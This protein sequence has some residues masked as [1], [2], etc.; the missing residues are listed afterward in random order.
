MKIAKKIFK[1]GGITLLLL[2]IAMIAIPF[3]FKDT[4]KEKV[5]EMAN[6]NL[7]A[8]IALQDVDIS[9]FKNF[10]KAQVTLNDFVLVNKEPFVGDTLFA[11]KHID[12]TLSIKDLLAGNYNLLG[13]NVKDASVYIHLNKEGVGNFD[14]AIPSDKP[15]EES[16][17]IKLDIQQYN[18]ENLK[19]T[20]KMDD[21]NLFMEVADI[22]HSGKGNF[23]EE[24][25]DLDTQ[26]KANVTFAM[27]K[28]TFMKQ[29]PITLQAILGIDLK[30]QKYTFKQNKAT[31]NRLDLV[32]DGFIQLLEEGQRY[33]LTFSTPTN[34]FQNFL[35]LI[36]E[37]YSKSIENVKTTGNL[38][39]KG[40]A[41]GDMVGDKI[42][43][44]G[45]E[46]Y[47]DNASFKYPNLPKTVR[48][49]TI[50]LKINN[51]TGITNDTK[52]NLNKF[53]MSIDQDHFSARANVSNIVV[54]PF[55][56]LAVKGTINLANLS[57]AYPISL[58][59]KFSGILRADIAT[60]LDM[61]SVE[62]KNYQNIKAQ[63]NLSL[64]QFVYAGEEF[65]KP[66]H[67]DNLNVAFSPSHIGLSQFDARTG[68]TDLHLTGT[69]DN[70][71]GFAF[72][73]E[74]LKGNFNLSSNKLVVNDFMQPAAET[75]T[76]KKETKEAPK[77]TTKVPA[78]AAIKVP[79]FL[80]CTLTAKANTVLYDN[81]KLSNVSGKLIIKDEKVALENLK[82]DIFGGNIVLSGDVSTKEK[83]PTFDV[84]LNLNRVNI[85]EAFSQIT[86]LEK[87]APIAKVVQGKVNTVINVKGSLKNDLTP[88]INSVSGDLFAALIDSKIDSHGSALL[89]ALDSQFTGLNLN[90]LNLKDV[91]A[92]VDF[93]D[94]KVKIKP[95]TIKYKDVA[96]EVAGSHGFDQ[97]M[98]YKLTFNVPPQMLGKE[99]E[100]LL[101]KLTPE[102]QKKI[103]NLPV[104][105]TVGGTF[106]KPQVSTDAK[107]VV[108]DL[109]TQI[110]K[111]QIN[112]LTAKGT[113]ALQQA[114]GSKTSSGT[115][116]EIT[117]TVGGL[118]KNR[119]STMTKVK[120]KAKEEAKKE[121][122]KQLGN[123]L[124]G[125]GGKN[126]GE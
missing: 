28:S 108:K 114:L 57:Q 21:G 18:V 95:F 48:D 11:A 34:S 66:F 46:M 13:A 50:D 106:K 20:F 38:T 17:P 44:F 90:N 45:L 37:E 1:W 79:A 100:G 68:E 78:Q 33:D 88:E 36:P 107:T 101:S 125:L 77:T 115:A 122:K 59:K 60:Q 42:P 102:N 43:T 70:L 126:E 104:V 81:L 83:T 62:T 98:N 97:Q 99:A 63:G 86:M 2:I 6:K 92:A 82:S 69:I 85:P 39:L 7:K 12:V 53:T 111:N 65:V 112:N 35:A 5:I 26:T 30:N 93:E 47:A 124:K 94:G 24:V 54:N 8:N 121:A 3:F 51:T 89:S 84:D 118:M 96:I 15:E 10:P 55:V 120:E 56:D 27:D 58:D 80:D 91:K 75:T 40:F 113:D 74:I 32:F 73:K 117:K 22:Y 119:D 49:I 110:A 64:S 71:Y 76:P 52:V 29:V 87:I 16:A 123:F 103:T 61:K 72:R 9:L 105:A 109:A 67:I 41:K 31:V 23:A 25:L 4:I 14:I 19:F 116:G